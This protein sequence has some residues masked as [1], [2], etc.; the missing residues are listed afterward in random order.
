MP[1]DVMMSIATTLRYSTVL[2]KPLPLEVCSFFRPVS[3]YIPP[4]LLPPPQAHH[5]FLK[6]KGTVGR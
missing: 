1:C 5:N 6:H 4:P 3:I 2:S